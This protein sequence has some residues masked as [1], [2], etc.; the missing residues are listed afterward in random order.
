MTYQEWLDFLLKINDAIFTNMEQLEGAVNQRLA[1]INNILMGGNTA[2]SE[3][4]TYTKAEDHT[5]KYRK[6]LKTLM[7]II[8]KAYLNDD[9]NIYGYK[10]ESKSVTE[11]ME[12]LFNEE[13]G[14]KAAHRRMG[15]GSIQ[16]SIP[17]GIK[18]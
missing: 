12:K 10:F 17:M 6:D 5:K 11:I 16:V 3:S 13:Q 18:R 14:S 8:Q 9:W 4:D 2:A 7:C 1:L 15:G